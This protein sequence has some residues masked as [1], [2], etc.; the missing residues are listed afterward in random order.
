MSRA[1]LPDLAVVAVGGAA[2]S[3]ARY[4]TGL[5]IGSPDANGGFPFATLLVNVLGAFLLGALVEVVARR[6]GE[7]GR[8]RTARLLLGTGVLGGFTTYS[9]YA[10]DTAR[11]LLEGR[12]GVALGYAAATLLA[13]AA[14]SGLGI[15][16]GRGIAPEA[17]HAEDAR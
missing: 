17:A 10:G 16:A 6:G 7:R 13:G 8:W 12:I 11:L 2:G 14:A 4:G 9:L 3:L 5:L 1:T 15:L